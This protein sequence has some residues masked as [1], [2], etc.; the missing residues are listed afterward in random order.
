MKKYKMWILFV[1]MPAIIDSIRLLAN[2]KFSRFDIGALIGLFLAY[3][4][5]SWLDKGLTDGEKKA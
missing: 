5:L 1:V 4:T 2:E 3:G